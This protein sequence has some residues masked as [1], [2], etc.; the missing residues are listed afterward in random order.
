MK[1]SQRSGNSIRTRFLLAVLVVSSAAA[2]SLLDSTLN[3]GKNLFATA[4]VSVLA[5]GALSSFL[6]SRVENSSGNP[7]F[8]PG[9]SFKTVDMV[10]DFLFGK[11]LPVSSAAVW[12]TGCIANS[13]EI[14]NSGEELCRGLLFSY[15]IVQTFKIATG[16]ERPDGSNNR[17][18]PSAHAAGASCI[19]AILWSRYGAATGIPLSALAVYTCLSRVNLGK[20]FPSDVLM[21]AAIGAACGIASSM[22]SASQGTGG[23]KFSVSID[24]EGRITPGLW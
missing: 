1:L 8:M 16:R 12:L 14:K 24:T 22:V 4:P 2:G 20:H 11:V 3:T 6:I 7:G 10:D 5:T 18:F 9:S 13:E 19:A 15:G 21:G 17:S 23:V